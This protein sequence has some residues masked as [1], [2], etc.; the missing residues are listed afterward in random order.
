M[1]ELASDEDYRLP[2]G[3]V[4]IASHRVRLMPLISSQSVREAIARN[5]G[6]IT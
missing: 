3:T 2:A 5:M 6:K 4:C 1:I